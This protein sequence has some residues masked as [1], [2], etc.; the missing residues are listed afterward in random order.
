MNNENFGFKELELWKKARG[1]LT[2]TINHVIDALDEDYIS[3]QQLFLF[4][5]KRK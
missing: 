5:Q 3:E 1:S 2:E 4:K